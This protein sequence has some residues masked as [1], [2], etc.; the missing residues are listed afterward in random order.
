LLTKNQK[1]L[2][3]NINIREQ[4]KVTKE[5]NQHNELLEKEK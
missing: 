5:Q 3:K 1:E 4:K 2:N